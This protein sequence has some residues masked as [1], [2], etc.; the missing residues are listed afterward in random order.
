MFER[1]LEPPEDPATAAP[2]LIVTSL[3][4]VLHADCLAVVWGASNHGQAKRHTGPHAGYWRISG[5]PTY[6]CVK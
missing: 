6:V 3:A 4:T 2:P 5:K 1:F